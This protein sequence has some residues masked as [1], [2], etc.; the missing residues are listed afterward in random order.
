MV[1]VTRAYQSVGTGLKE[2]FAR[3]VLWREDQGPWRV[4]GYSVMT[5][6]DLAAAAGLELARAEMAKLGRHICPA[7]ADQLRDK[8]YVDDGA[9]AAASRRELEMI[10]GERL[11]DGIYTGL[12]AKVMATV[13]MVPKL[14][15]IPGRATDEEKALL[16]GKVLGLE[17]NVDEDTI[18]FHLKTAAQVGDPRDRRKKI[19]LIWTQREVEEIR[20][21]AGRLSLREVLSWTMSVYDPLGLV[22]PLILRAK[23]MIRRLQGR[24]QPIPWDEDMS[25]EEKPYGPPSSQRFKTAALCASQGWRLLQKGGEVHIVAFADGSLAAVCAA[26]YAVWPLPDPSAATFAS[27]L[28]M[29]KCRLAPLGAPRPRGRSSPPS[30]WPT[31]WHTWWPP[32]PTT[33]PPLCQS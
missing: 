22:S 12:L 21:C 16:G 25:R 24:G 32:R 5:F 11:P 17:Y 33:G 3:L 30:C 20:Q 19:P 6:G 13:K 4:L 27:T 8:M 10:R 15:V 23:V 26:V 18:D 14:V 28:I 29:A 7:T 9:I 31:G 2:K 1:V